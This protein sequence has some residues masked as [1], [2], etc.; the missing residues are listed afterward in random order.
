MPEEWSTYQQLEN[1]LSVLIAN[2]PAGTKLP[3]EPKLA[4]QLGVSRTTLREAMRAFESQGLLRRR[5]GSGTFVMGQAQVIESGLEVLE[6]IETQAA[7]AGLNVSMADY[8]ISRV[9]ASRQQAQKLNL[10]EGD[11]LL[12]IH[13]VILMEGSP[14]AYL[15]DILPE[16]LLSADTLAEKF[17]GSVLDLLIQSSNPGLSVSKT[18]ISAVQANALLAKSLEIQHGDTLLLLSG[19]LYDD[20]GNPVNLSFSYFLPGKFRLYLNRKIGGLNH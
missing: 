13:R 14:A 18:E 8:K 10:K 2:A 4:K 12:E 11:P 1:E 9:K 16:N 15:I 19:N 17:T 20:E 7:R 3:P 5:Q 6:S